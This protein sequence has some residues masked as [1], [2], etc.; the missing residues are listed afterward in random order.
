LD[1]TL[2]LAEIQ[3]RFNAEWVLLDEPQASES[4]EIQAGRVVFHSKD[5]EEV[6]RKAVD[7]RPKRFAMLF[8]G[9]IPLDTA[10]VL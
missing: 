2:T 7:L 4:L 6:Y 10:V 5:R 8:T 1:E 3:S 9:T